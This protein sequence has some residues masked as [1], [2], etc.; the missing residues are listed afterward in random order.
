M[1]ESESFIPAER[2]VRAILFVLTWEETRAMT[3][4]V[5]APEVAES[6]RSQSV[7]L[8]RS[9]NPKYRPFAFDVFNVIRQLM[10]P[11]A[12]PKRRKIGFHARNAEA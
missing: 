3:P 6:S 11:P 4:Q 8:K 2:I 10:E 12:N 5:P 1:G 9:K 7:T